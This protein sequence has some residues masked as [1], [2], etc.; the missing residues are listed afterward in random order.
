M[1]A[2]SLK[3]KY[4]ELDNRL[5][6]IVGFRNLFNIAVMMVAFWFIYSGQTG[7]FADSTIILVGGFIMLVMGMKW[8]LVQ[9]RENIDATEVY[10]ELK[11]EELKTPAEQQ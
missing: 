7:V 9:T 10:D 6:Y 2:K 3:Q 1:E 5:T 4:S 8:F 11:A